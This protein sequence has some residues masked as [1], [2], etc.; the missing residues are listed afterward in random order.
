MKCHE[1]LQYLFDSV[2]VSHTFE[3]FFGAEPFRF[4]KEGCL[5]ESQRKLMTSM[6]FLSFKGMRLTQTAENSSLMRN[7]FIA[8]TIH[9]DIVRSTTI[10]N[11]H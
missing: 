11:L 1:I 2:S 4:E 8:C 9:I 7:M 10:L 5:K 6:H 3:P